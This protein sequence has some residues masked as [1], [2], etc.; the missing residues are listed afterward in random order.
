MI[1]FKRSNPFIHLNNIDFAIVGLIF[2]MFS[3]GISAQQRNTQL[4]V[5]GHFQYA[6]DDLRGENSDSYFT[7]G[8]Q[9]FFVTSNLS[10]RISFLGETVVRYDN[11]TSSKFSPS[12]ERA[13]LKFEI[14]RAHV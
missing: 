13:Q 11:S 2:L 9:D 7:L 14:G 4:K 8:E 10:D 12:I 3:S 6:F 5:Y 1:Y